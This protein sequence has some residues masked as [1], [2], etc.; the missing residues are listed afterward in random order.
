MLFFAINLNINKSKGSNILMFNAEIY[1]LL[2][3]IYL[4]MNVQIQVDP[5]ST[6]ISSTYLL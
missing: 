1:F 5:K 6:K 3:D 4:Q 2:E